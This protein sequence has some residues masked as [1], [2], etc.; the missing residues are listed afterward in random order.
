MLQQLDRRIALLGVTHKAPLEE[1]NALRAELV[2]RRQL[3]R[4]ALGN[5]VHDGPLVVEVRPRPAAR[6]HLEYDAPQ[7]PDVDGAKVARVFTLDYF[8][9]H[10]HGGAGHGFVG[11]GAGQVLDE[12]AALSGDEL[13]GAEVDIFD[14]AVVV[15]EDVCG[16]VVSMALD[17]KRR[18]V[19][20]LLSGLISR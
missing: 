5:V 1:I 9:G 6:R 17:F 8:R 13:G 20:G 7:R 14:Y 3:R 12:G 4:V 16:E 19:V 10:V 2:G 18:E 15:E 11:L